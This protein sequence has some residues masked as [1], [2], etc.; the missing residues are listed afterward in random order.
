MTTA[1]LERADRRIAKFRD[2]NWGK[3]FTL[4]VIKPP[5]VDSHERSTS[6]VCNEEG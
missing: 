5:K 4:S 1:E 2:R 6:G 3:V